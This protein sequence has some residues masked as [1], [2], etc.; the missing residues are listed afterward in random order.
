MPGLRAPSCVTGLTIGGGG[1]VRLLSW[2][3]VIHEQKG[4]WVSEE[5]EKGNCRWAAC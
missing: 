1:S 3:I 4:D 2:E 5:E